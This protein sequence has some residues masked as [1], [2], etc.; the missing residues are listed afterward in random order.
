MLRRKSI[1][2]ALA[3]AGRAE[4]GLHRTLGARELVFLGIG[5]VVGAGIFTSTGE[6]A[7]GSASHPGAGPALVIAYLVTGVVCGLAALAY[8][9]LAALVPVAG[10]A[11]TYAYVALGEPIA[12]IIGWD[13]VIEYAVGNIYVA[14]SWGQYLG[15]FLRGTFDVGFPA[16]MATDWQT[17]ART[18]EIAALAPRIGGVVV[19]FNLPAIL[20]TAA[21]TVVL[22]LGVRESTRVNNALV[23]GKLSLIAVFVAVGSLFVERRNYTPFAPNGLSGIGSAAALA[24]FSYI[25]FDALS[26]TAE[27]VRNPSRDIPR[28]MIGTLAAC[29]VVYAAVSVV[30]T[31]LV[32]SSQLGRGDPLAFALRAAG[33]EA[34]SNVMAL[35]AVIAVTAV[36]LVFQMGQ[37]RIL[38]AM[39]RDGLLPPQFGRVHP[40][41]RTPVFGTVLTGLFVA[42][43]ASLVTPAQALELTTIGTLLAFV[44]VAV[45]VIV[46][47]IYEPGRAR[48]FRCP[49][50]PYVPALAALACL[51][52]MA[53]LPP[54]T[55]LRLFAWMAVGLVIYAAYGRRRSK[56][57]GGS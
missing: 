37:P 45:G 25:G 21:L 53:Q 19:A 31:G 23:I 44:L 46:L 26:T 12:W 13:L 15:T 48:P 29:A 22:V 24:F 3:E 11:Y 42:V 34:L 5:A 32:P 10:S 14:Q 57:R 36:L 7:A 41:F 50:S 38:M 30:M 6:L 55:W 28:G 52:L 49:G 18:P 43:S 40:R 35:G 9:E 51:G 20:V 1:D 16:W 27:E 47:R 4:L 39:A 33:L 17:A 2:A 54:M 56:L 8:A